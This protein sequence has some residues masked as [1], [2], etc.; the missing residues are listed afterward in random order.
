MKTGQNWNTLLQSD[1]S[2]YLWCT[3]K[4]GRCFNCTEQKDAMVKNCF[5]KTTGEF[6][7]CSYDAR[8]F[9]PSLVSNKGEGEA[10][11]DAIRKS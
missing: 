2:E 9:N 8:P 5:T 6:L 10:E 11:D 3:S 4:L 1:R 7:I